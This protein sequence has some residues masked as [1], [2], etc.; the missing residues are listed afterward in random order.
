MDDLI[1][2]IEDLKRVDHHTVKEELWRLEGFVNRYSRHQELDEESVSDEIQL[3]YFKLMHPDITESYA[4]IVANY[5]AKAICAKFKAP[6]S[7][8]PER[9]IDVDAMM[10]IINKTQTEAYIFHSD[11]LKIVE[12]LKST[13]HLWLKE[14]EAK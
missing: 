8:N 5:L 1:K 11:K 7:I 13:A 4:E 14:K 2:V 6:Q 10:K 12:A 9:E 3:R